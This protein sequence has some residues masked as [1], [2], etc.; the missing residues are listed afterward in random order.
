M[1]NKKKTAILFAYNGAKFNGSQI[2]NAHENVRT[3]EAELQSALHKARCISSENYGFLNKVKW[4]RA[5]RTDK[6]VHALCAVVGLKMEWETKP[7]EEILSEINSY[8]PDDVRLI[9]L[10]LVANQFNAKNSSSFREYQYLFP[11]N[12]FSSDNLEEMIERLNFIAKY[13][14]GTHSFHNYSKDIM[15]DKPEAKRYIV[16]FEVEN[17]VV[18]YSGC[19]YLK[20]VITGQSFLYHQ[21]RKMIGM[22]ICVYLGRFRCE[23]IVKSFEND[24]FYVPLA[25]AEGLSLNRVHFTVY[26]KKQ[27]HRPVVVNEDEEKLVQGFYESSILP[28][29]HASWQ[30]FKD[31]AVAEAEERVVAT[32]TQVTSLLTCE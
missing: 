14:H 2:Q 3:V 10:K 15:P 5:S 1:T 6:G 18:E 7:Y 26:N 9:S 4:T 24:P 31:W 17:K 28:T 19:S 13:F 20:F 22:T 12:V 25:P 30:T 29:V 23:D 11:S 32:E 16:K 8:L 21:I 27:G